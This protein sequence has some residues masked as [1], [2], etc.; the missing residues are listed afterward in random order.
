[1]NSCVSDVLDLVFSIHIYV[2]L[3]V[4]LV[5]AKFVLLVVYCTRICGGCTC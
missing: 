2:E 1:M 3:F 4:A 5:N